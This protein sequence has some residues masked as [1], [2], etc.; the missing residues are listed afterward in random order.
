LGETDYCI[1]KEEKQVDKYN[2]AGAGDVSNS[3]SKL[4]ETLRNTF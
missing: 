2:P 4:L 3:E 1:F